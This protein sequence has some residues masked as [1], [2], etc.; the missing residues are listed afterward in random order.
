MTIRRPDPRGSDR[1]RAGDRLRQE[2]AVWI[3]PYLG[4]DLS[5]VRPLIERVLG[6][7]GLTVDPRGVDRD[8]DDIEESYRRGGGEF[9]VV[10]DAGGRVVGSCGVWP[11]PGEPRLCELRKMYLAP[12]LRGRG[13][14]RQLLDLALDHAQ[15]AGFRRVE[16]ETNHAMT[17]AIALYES[18]GFVETAAPA[19]ATRCDRRFALDLG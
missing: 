19:G 3:R 16:L 17:A 4:V 8:L 12:E 9:W 13:I 1:E 18:A 15:A 2:A 11:D 10:E 6:E 5:A 7:F 14:G